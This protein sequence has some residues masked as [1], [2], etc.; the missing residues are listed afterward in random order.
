MSRYW[1]NL[2]LHRSLFVCTQNTQ[3]P[4]RNSWNM[5]IS[6][7]VAMRNVTQTE[8]GLLKREKENVWREFHVWGY[9]KKKKNQIARVRKHKG[10]IRSRLKWHK[11]SAPSFKKKKKKKSQNSYTTITTDHRH[12]GCF[13]VEPAWDRIFKTN[14]VFGDLNTP[15]YSDFFPFRL[16]KHKQT[17]TFAMCCYLFSVL[18]SHTLPGCSDHMFITA[19]GILPS[20]GQTLQCQL[21]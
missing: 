1:I 15:W 9:L 2:C 16:Q 7:S 18:H 17:L 14:A 12:S 5:Q 8:L 10:E 11:A 3:R 21:S 13:K 6:I 20:G 4:N 19:S